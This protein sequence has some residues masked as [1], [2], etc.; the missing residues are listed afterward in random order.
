LLVAIAIGLS[1]GNPIGR[2]LSQGF[3]QA[4]DSAFVLHENELRATLMWT[5]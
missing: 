1:I 2:V 4:I 5:S 3:S